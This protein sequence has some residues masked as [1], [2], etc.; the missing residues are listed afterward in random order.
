MS[1]KS[2]KGML[3]D[4][5]LFIETHITFHIWATFVLHTKKADMKDERYYSFNMVWDWIRDFV[6]K[7]LGTFLKMQPQFPPQKL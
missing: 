2:S 4:L 7:T 3:K 1:M 5:K 6:N